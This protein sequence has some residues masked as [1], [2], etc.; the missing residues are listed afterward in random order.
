[1]SDARSDDPALCAAQAVRSTNGTWRP[2]LRKGGKPRA[3]AGLTIERYFTRP[4]ED[5]FAAV[6]WELCSA[7]IASETGEV[8]F[9]Q[10]GV[11]MPKGWS[12]LATNVVVS[13][14]FRGH[15]GTPERESSVKQLIGRVVGRLRE[16]GDASGYFKTAA[17]GDAF[18]DELTH[19]LVT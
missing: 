4:D 15:V 17:D 7:K 18:R 2:R 9:E 11:E 6:E 19:V 12:Q 3:G 5:P 8:L 14:Y 1:M 10:T 16:W 13:K